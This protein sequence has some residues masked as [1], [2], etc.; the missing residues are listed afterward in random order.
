MTDLVYT[1]KRG[2][3]VTD[4]LLVAQKFGKNHRDVLSSIDELVKGVAEKSAD[5]FYETTYTHPQNKQEYRKY[6]MNKDGFSILV[7][8]FTGT[9][10]L[11]FKIEFIDAF[12]KMETMLKSDDYILARSQEIL[13]KR[14]Q[15]ANQRLQLLENITEMQEE[16]LKLMHPKAEYY[17]EVLQTPDTSTFT[18]VAKRLG[19]SSANKLT[20]ELIRMNIAYKQSG[21]WQLYSKYAGNG[22]TDVRVNK[23]YH[24]DG[25]PGTSTLTVWTEKGIKFLYDKLKIKQNDK[26]N[27]KIHAN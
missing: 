7:M 8:G 2:A 13:Q 16:H 26:S 23:F 9:D 22:Y 17:D 20:S 27:E 5:L 1:S 12:N 25:T 14:L 4:S 10:A 15:A 3:P 18:Q 24:S 6:I 19:F 11:Q 21:Q